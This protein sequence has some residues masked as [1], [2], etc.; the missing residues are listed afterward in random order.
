MG[1]ERHPS[2]PDT[3]IPEILLLILKSLIQT[4]NDEI[5][6]TFIAL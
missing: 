5:G 1:G 6:L 2:L 3:R 4:L